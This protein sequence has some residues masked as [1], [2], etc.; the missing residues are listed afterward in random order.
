MVT[1]TE[2][3]QFRE[4]KDGRLVLNYH[5]GQVKA[6]DSKARFV[7]MLAGTQGGKTCY[8]MHWLYDEIQ[9]K[10]PGDYLAITAT[11][12]LLKLKMLPE[13]LYVFDTLLGLGTFKESDRVFLFHDGQTRVIFGSAT[14]PES[15]ESATAKAAWLDEA[16]QKQFK[17]EAWEAIQRRLSIH[18]GRVLFTTTL[19]GLSWLKNEIYDRWQSGQKDI[20]VIQFESTINPTFPKEEFERARSVLPRWKF[21]LFYQGQYDK[22]AGLIY[23]AFDQ[24]ACKTARFPLPR[25]WPRFVGHDFG[26]ANPAAMFYAQDPATGYF[27][28]YHEY[29]PGVG[30]STAEH[31]EEFKRITVGTNV[32]KRA[33]GSHQEEEIRQGYTAHG[34]PI[35]EPKV[36][37]VEAGI[38]RVYALHKLNKLFVFDDLYAYLDEKLSYS[39][40]LDDN[41][42]PTDE[43]EDKERFHLMDAERYILSDFTPETV[44]IKRVPVTVHSVRQ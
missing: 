21:R 30:R 26:G 44:I 33:G 40:K 13:F 3:P 22:P 31:V 11:F 8:G 34:W 36:K 41:Y 42:N 24:D 12:P 25:E 43:I 20:D 4:L 6:D 18:Q 10:G 39:R 5:P 9:R 14:N 23:D 19:Y 27:Y 29:L 17:R 38:D 1:A 2:I 35:Q 15:I 28:A 37:T 32:L 16:G 7:V